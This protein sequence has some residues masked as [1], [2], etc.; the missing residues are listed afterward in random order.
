MEPEKYFDETPNEEARRFYDQLEEPSRPLCEGS[1]H[2]A[3]ADN[4]ISTS[5]PP[6]DRFKHKAIYHR[7]HISQ[8][9]SLHRRCHTYYSLQIAITICEA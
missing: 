8:S 9:Q 4:S 2:F 1:P 5:P 3:L 6:P 7:V